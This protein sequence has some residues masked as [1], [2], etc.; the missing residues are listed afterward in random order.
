MIR[1]VINQPNY[2]PNIGGGINTIGEIKSGN[3]ALFLF[4]PRDIVDHYKRP[5]VYNF[6]N[7]ITE[8]IVE[9]IIEHPT[10]SNTV[11]TVLN[12]TPHISEAIVPTSQGGIPIA[13][14]AYSGSWMFVL[15][16]DEPTDRQL[17]MSNK[18]TV[19]T[20][21]IGICGQEPIS[22][23]GMMSATPEQ[24]LNPECQLIITKRLQMTKFMTAGVSGMMPSVKPTIDD[25]IV[26][27]DRTLWGSGPDR[28]NPAAPTD[29]YFTL[30]P[31]DVHHNVHINPD[32]VTSVV[33]SGEA[34]NFKGPSKITAQYESPKQHMKQ[35]LT[36]FATGS[37]NLSY[38]DA[39]GP[40]GNGVGMYDK[41]DANF[42]GN[43]K[44]V[45]D[46]TRLMSHGN[47]GDTINDI[48]YTPMTLN[49]VMQMYHP[50]VFPIVT[51]KHANA[52][53]IP[54]NYVS[55]SNVFSSL[56][57]AVLPSYLNATGL[58]SV[59]FMYNSTQEAFKVMHVDSMLNCTQQELQFKWRAFAHLITNE[60]FPVL[61]GNGGHFDLQVMSSLNS[62]SDVIL[63]FYDFEPLPVGVIYQENSVLG[64]IVSPLVGNDEHLKYN[65]HQFNNLMM[66]VSSRVYH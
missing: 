19:R 42:C 27:Y 5:L 33:D 35:I 21:L 65:S 11:Q 66:N 59:S 41:P 28:Y 8:S 13:T 48:I 40:F 36:A 60:L 47:P 58:S 44:S 14:S 1:N 56:V 53:I 16:F 55:I 31:F 6:N 20:I 38:D 64:G 43:V 3:S 26:Q 45:L 22:H 18:L 39:T 51:P 52:E 37:A 30:M 62:T 25:N 49:S 50:K 9:H 24:F 4:S 61:F 10:H 34:I 54:Q 23:N 15:I 7:Q 63:N 57:C 12:A 46:E 32:E 2:Q 29:Q 17:I